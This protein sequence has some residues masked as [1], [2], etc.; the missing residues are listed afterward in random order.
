MAK[1]TK[2]EQR[3]KAAAR[4][5]K[6]RESIKEA[7]GRTLKV[8]LDSEAADQ[9][10]QIMEAVKAEAPNTSQSEVVRMMIAKTYQ[11]ASSLAVENNADSVFNTN[12]ESN[13]NSIEK[14]LAAGLNISC[15]S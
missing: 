9:F 8:T 2:R 1:Q 10:Q 15:K 12:T 7:G 3:Q 13:M 6:H 14:A 4:Q 5:K 11:D